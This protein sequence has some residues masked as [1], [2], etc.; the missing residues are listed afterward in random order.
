MP[1]LWIDNREVDMP[2]GSTLLEAARQLGI[3]VPALCYVDG[4]RP[5]TSCM[6][7]VMKVVR[8]HEGDL[9]NTGR[10]VPSCATVAEEGMRVE[11]E[12]DAVRRV[13]KTTLE[14][15]LSDHAGECRAPCQFA[16]PFDTDLP[17][18][19]RQIAAGRIADAIATLRTD[20]P[21]AAALARVAP[22]PS[23]AGCRRC[24]IDAAV[25][26][27]LL[28]RYVADLDRAS[29]TPHVPPRQADS[30]KCVAIVGAGPAGLSAAY[31]LLQMGHACTVFDARERPGGSLRGVPPEQLPP[32]VLAAEIGLIE[33][34]GARFEPNAT[35]GQRRADVA[36]EPRTGRRLEDLRGDFDAVLVAVGRLGDHDDLGLPVAAGR[37]RINHT[38]HE[39]DIPGVFAAGDAVL[40]R[41]RP[42]QAAAAGKSAALCVDQYL[43]GVAVTGRGK[44]FALG[45]GRPSN[46][47]IAALMV[48]TSPASRVGPNDE[49]AGLTDDE[50]RAE[51]QRCL[52]CDCRDIAGCKLRKYAEMYGAR[53]RRY[54][55]PRR[56]TERIATHPDIVFEPG[57]CILCGLCVQIAEEFREPLGLTQVGRGFDVRVA[58]PFDAAFAEALQAAARR[59]VEVCPTSALAWKREPPPDARGDDACTEE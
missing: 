44:L 58:V 42:V 27:G 28:K 5:S 38:T 45:T 25:S 59:C 54:H 13:R 3:D 52:H 35:I 21:L 55:G 48:D 39:T 15:L 30:G 57:K 4:L 20:V 37:L 22:E 36:A 14:L 26:I 40:P 34:L 6:I 10:L 49:A 24:A 17:R 56:R 41:G 33:K 7:C 43:R 23:E 53:A 51:A 9:A 16:C 18:M 2:A 31:F 12:T 47:E 50:A 1:R 19:I 46:E 11:S 8:R 32:E 29:A